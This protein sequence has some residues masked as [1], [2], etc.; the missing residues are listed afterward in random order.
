MA[1]VRI[2]KELKGDIIN[3]SMAKFRPSI[4]AAQD[5]KPDDVWGD[6]IYD[7]VWGPYREQMEALPKEFF[8]YQETITILRVGSVG[9]SFIATLSQPRPIATINT[10]LLTHEWGGNYSLLPAPEWHDL[11]MA[12]EAWKDRY[13]KALARRKAVIEG[14]NSVL[15]TYKTLALA[16]KAWPPLWELVPGKVKT[17]HKEV[18][19]RTKGEKPGVDAAKLGAMTSAL[20]AIKLGGM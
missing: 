3:A 5:S 9:M 17:Q 19:E 13:D 14:V 4:E 11:I 6:Y 2:T 20:T 7:K 18:K 10:H 15:D 1:V 12:A 8:S 16:L